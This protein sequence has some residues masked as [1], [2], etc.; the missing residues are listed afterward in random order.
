MPRKPHFT[1][2]LIVALAVLVFLAL[3]ERTRSRVRLALTSL[4]LPLFGLAGSAQ[5]TSDK[6]CNLVTPRTSLTER[7]ASLERTNEVLRLALAEA[8]SARREN[9]RLRQM[10]GYAQRSRWRLK[11]AR[12][13]G[14]DPANW[15]RSAH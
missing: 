8:E 4:F 3:P 1:L 7:I 14:R 5:A 15:W 9:D 13:I 11:P 6:V 10:L 2:L 12:V